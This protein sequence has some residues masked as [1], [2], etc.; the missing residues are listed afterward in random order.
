MS[1]DTRMSADERREEV[2]RAAAGAFAS[3]GYEGTSTEDVARK[4]GISQP[5]IF[6]L[7]GSKRELFIAVMERSF[8]HLAK[9]FEHAARGLSGEE[10][11]EAMGAAYMQL[12]SDPVVLLVELHSFTAAVQDELVREAAQKGMRKVWETAARASGMD[13]DCLRDWLAKGMLCNVVAALG[14]K[15]LDEG[16]ARDVVA[17]G[18]WPVGAAS[19]VGG[20]Q[21]R[22][23]TA[24][25]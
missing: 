22:G 8:N 1:P 21:A 4:A 24:H 18:K 23:E 14:L 12:I 17:F 7:F 15:E 10:A 20:G 19:L 13:A 5:Y 2:L 9:T 25:S 11:L 16:W 3:G 6:R